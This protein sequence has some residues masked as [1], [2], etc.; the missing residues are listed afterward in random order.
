MNIFM[1]LLSN[2][3]NLGNYV[4]WILAHLIQIRITFSL[5][6]IKHVASTASLLIQPGAWFLQENELYNPCFVN[7][8]HH[9]M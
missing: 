5:S 8:S 6:G 1:N 2:F 9:N 4:A 3:L 7:D